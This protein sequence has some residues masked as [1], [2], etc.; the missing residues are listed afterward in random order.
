MLHYTSNNTKGSQLTYRL[1]ES[2]VLKLAEYGRS[3]G[4]DKRNITTGVAYQAL[5]DF[6][7]AKIGIGHRL[8]K[9][10]SQVGA[11]GLCIGLPVVGVIFTLKYLLE[12]PSV[13][14]DAAYNIANS[15]AAK[16]LIGSG[17]VVETPMALATLGTGALVTMGT[18]FG[19]KVAYDATVGTMQWTGLMMWGFFVHL[20]NKASDMSTEYYGRIEREKARTQEYSRLTTFIQEKA[21]FD[22]MADYFEHTLDGIRNSPKE[23]NKL[24]KKIAEYEEYMPIYMEGLSGMNLEPSQVREILDKTLSVINDIQSTQFSFREGAA[25]EVVNKYNVELMSILSDEEIK[26]KIVTD[27]VKSLV[28]EIENSRLGLS[29]SVNSYVNPIFQGVYSGAK[30]GATI[31]FVSIPLAYLSGGLEQVNWAAKCYSGETWCH[32]DENLKV[33][34]IMGGAAVV[35][36][37]GAIGA[38]NSG[39]KAYR[40]ESMRYDQIRR[41]SEEVLKENTRKINRTYIDMFNGMASYL[42]K[43]KPTAEVVEMVSN[44]ES[45]LPLVIENLKTVSQIEDPEALV[46]PLKKVV[47]SILGTERKSI[48]DEVAE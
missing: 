33:Y 27:K 34:G 28:S 14:S 31:S 43:Q 16:N 38:V 23:I 25:L 37:A 9:F 13:V 5:Q 15:D 22:G 18:G 47:K 24:L 39:A 17:G 7:N 35:A 4:M 46:A 3:G 26:R 12:N 21:V 36:S 11:Y 20:A 45:K 19:R 44:I 6:D 42:K 29:Y 32:K 2:N 48:G 40:K 41:D 30:T 1:Q 8:S 10:G